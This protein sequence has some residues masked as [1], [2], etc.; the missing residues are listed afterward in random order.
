[1]SSEVPVIA[2]I[3]ETSSHKSRA[4][5]LLPRSTGSAKVSGVLSTR[6]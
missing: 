2:S 1:M 5:E 3:L 4:K 6:P